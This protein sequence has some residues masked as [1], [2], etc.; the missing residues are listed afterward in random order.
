MTGDI[1]ERLERRS[2]RQAMPDDS[3]GVRADVCRHARSANLLRYSDV[4]ERLRAVLHGQ[5]PHQGSRRT[6]EDNTGRQNEEQAGQSG[7]EVYVAD[8]AHTHGHADEFTAFEDVPTYAGLSRPAGAERA[9]GKVRRQVDSP[10]HRVSVAS[11]R[12][13]PTAI[14]PSCGRLR[15][16]LKLWTNDFAPVSL[17]L[18]EIAERPHPRPRIRGR[19]ALSVDQSPCPPKDVPAPCAS[20]PSRPTSLWS[21]VG[22]RASAPRSPPPGSAH[23]GARQQPAGARWQL[24]SARCGCGCAARP[25]TAEPLRPRDRHHG[26]ALRREPV[27]QPRG[28]PVLLGPGRARGRARRAEHHAV[29][30]HRRPRGRRL[31]PG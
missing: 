13:D 24:Q 1:E 14:L 28:Q 12:P 9:P 6:A 11:T 4:H 3:H 22:W 29:P 18:S 15:P 8:V 5:T 25:P 16:C 30:Q 19:S 17:S 10:R 2:D 26:R 21:A 23:R 27:P 20:R 31:R 7:L